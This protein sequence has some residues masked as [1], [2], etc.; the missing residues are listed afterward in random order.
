[1]VEM[2][3]IMPCSYCIVV[4]YGKY[5]S[6]IFY[7]LLCIMHYEIV[8]CTSDITAAFFETFAMLFILPNA[9]S[10]SFSHN[11]FLIDII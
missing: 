10:P 9:H 2:L 4:V 7:N 1:M 3:C 6:F 11:Y 5:V 8:Y